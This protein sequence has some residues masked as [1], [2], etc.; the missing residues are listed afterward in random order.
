MAKVG[1]TQ[2][3]DVSISIVSHAHGQLVRMLLNDLAEH[4]AV[5]CEILLTLNIPEELAFDLESFPFDIK[6]IRNTYAHGFAANHNAAFLRASGKFFCVLNPDIRICSDPFPSLLACVRQ[7]NVGVAAPRVVNS[8]GEVEDSARPFP[9]PSI[10][11]AKALGLASGRYAIEDS[12]FFPDWVAGMFMLF[13]NEIFR[14]IG[15]FD[16]S[17]FLY[18]ED[19]DLCARLR[20]AGYRTAL[21]PDAVVI[22]D[23]R[24]SSHHSLKYFV[25]HARSIL[26][27]FL[28]DAYSRCRIS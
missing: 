14:R 1:N 15:G 6:V 22:H 3:F 27:F 10:L 24:R 7:E 5:P 17:Y 21:C 23:A 16:E 19:I 18:Y 25:W 13:P 28:S 11:V 9:T 4:C 20:I 12:V 8:R 26:R 2:T